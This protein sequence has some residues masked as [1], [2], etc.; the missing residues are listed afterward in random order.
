MK[1]DSDLIFENYLKSFNAPF[2][3]EGSIA[4]YEEQLKEWYQN[5]LAC[6]DELFEEGAIGDALSKVSGG[7][8]SVTGSAK[9]FLANKMLQPIVNWIVNGIQKL[10]GQEKEN[11]IKGLEKVFSDPNF[12]VKQA[13][14]VGMESEASEEYAFESYLITREYL[15]KNVFTESNI[16]IIF[17]SFTLLSEAAKKKSAKKGS[18]KSKIGLNVTKIAQPVIDAYNKALA[19]LNSKYPSGSAASNAAKRFNSAIRNAVQPSLSPEGSSII[20]PKPS[21]A[22]SAVKSKSPKTVSP[23]TGSTLPTPTGA[24]SLTAPKTS[25]SSMVPTEK[26]GELATTGSK[27]KDTG[28]AKPDY[29]DIESE[30]LPIEKKQG[31]IRKALSWMKD[32]PNATAAGIIGLASLVTLA[33]GGSFVPLLIAGLKGGGLGGIVSAIKQKV[34]TNEV[35]WKKVGSD[36]LKGAAGGSILGAITGGGQHADDTSVDD[37]SSDISDDTT[38][39]SSDMTDTEVS[40]PVSMPSRQSMMSHQAEP[41]VAPEP[42]PEVHATDAEFQKYN[43]KSYNPKSYDPNSWVDKLKRDAMDKLKQEGDGHISPRKYNDFTDKLKKLGSA[44]KGK[45]VEEIMGESYTAQY[46]RFF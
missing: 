27:R 18:P 16:E 30:T 15:L 25:S 17:G 12:A 29:I 33:T 38:S 37:S 20:Q 21:R 36:A 44:A 32:H 24:S 1:S 10:S 19:D 42:A 35:D 3:L 34:Q 43:S 2:A 8:K 45:S 14:S 11:A 41:D 9:T 22:A 5:D 39:D 28:L 4:T 7:L 31:F 26:G 23:T 6:I 40:E 13:K 46:L